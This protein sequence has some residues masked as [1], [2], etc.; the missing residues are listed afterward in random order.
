MFS[1][2]AIDNAVCVRQ[3]VSDT[4]KRVD[5]IT[6]LPLE[7]AVCYILPKILGDICYLPNV[8]PCFQVCRAW[9]EMIIQALRNVRFNMQCIDD[10][11]SMEDWMQ[12]GAVTPFI[13]TLDITESTPFAIWLVGERLRFP[14]LIDLTLTGK[15]DDATHTHI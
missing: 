9:N 11:W 6:Q 10:S 14:S 12:V 2:L 13:K 3:S 1:S 15:C 7:I 8:W 4:K 5:F